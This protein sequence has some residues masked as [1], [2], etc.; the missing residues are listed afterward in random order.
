MN[1]TAA[2]LIHRLMKRTGMTYDEAYE[3]LS[4]QADCEYDRRKDDE[5]ERELEQEQK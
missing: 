4:Y 2:H 3:E 5:L 1:L